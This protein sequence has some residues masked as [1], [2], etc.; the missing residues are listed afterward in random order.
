MSYW[1]PNMSQYMD[2]PHVLYY[3]CLSVTMKTYI[4]SS[5][6]YM[7][8]GVSD[9]AVTMLLLL[10]TRPILVLCTRNVS[11]SVLFIKIEMGR[12]KGMYIF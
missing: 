10:R 4:T 1:L 8:C 7:M 2:S 3:C 5:S 12:G 11:M 6:S 9:P